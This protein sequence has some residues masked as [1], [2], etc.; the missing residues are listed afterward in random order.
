MFQI[1]NSLLGEWC[2][3][4]IRQRASEAEP[5]G[6]SSSSTSQPPLE[7]NGTTAGTAGKT[8]GKRSNEEEGQ[9]EENVAKHLRTCRGKSK[10]TA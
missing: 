10:A 8:T 3:I 4:I 9:V 7:A 5:Q 6:C 1:I 2:L